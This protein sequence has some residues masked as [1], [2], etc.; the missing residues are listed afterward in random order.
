MFTQTDNAA[1]GARAG[2]R[3][4]QQMRQPTIRVRPISLAEA[5]RLAKEN[6]IAAITAA[7]AVRSREQRDSHR[8]A[9]SSTR[10]FSLSAGQGISAGD[11]VGQS[12]TLVPYTSAWTY[13][14]G[15]SAQVD[16]VRRRQDVRRRPRARRRT[17]QAHEA[18]AG[19]ATSSASRSTSRRSTTPSLAANEADGRGARAARARASSSSQM[20]I[21]KV[22]A[23]AANVADS[24][25]SVVQVGN[26]QLAILTAQQNAARG[27]RD[28]HAA[29][30]HAVPRHR[31]CR[32]IRSSCRV[33]PIDSAAVMALALDGPTI[34]QSQAQITSARRVAALREDAVFPDDQRSREH[35]PAAARRQP[36][37]SGS[38]PYPYTRGV[39]LQPELSDLQSLSA[40]EPGRRRR[41]SALENAEAQLKDQRL[42]AQQTIITQLGLLRNAEEQMRMQQIS[43]RATEEALR[44]KQQRYTLGAGTLLDVLTSQSS[45]VAARQRLIQARLDYRNARAQIEAVIGRD[46]PVSSARRSPSNEGPGARFP[47]LVSCARR[48]I[49]SLSATVRPRRITPRRRLQQFPPESVHIP[50]SPTS[51]RPS[52]LGRFSGDRLT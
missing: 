13:N 42:A 46:L 24:L 52:P 25:N 47:P 28:A 38:D 51:P 11:R 15:L 27:E 9:R 43:V 6:N 36:T 37:A 2:R 4:A 23:G 49:R 10:R 8:Q 40:R 44:V 29:R 34:R 1:R 22:N 21:A 48:G 35:Q 12:G 33:P 39:N 20:T 14:T 50:D 31:A 45:L 5:I 7:N 26:A 3:A 19:H 30:R 16:A 18:V 32:P 17:S 41:R